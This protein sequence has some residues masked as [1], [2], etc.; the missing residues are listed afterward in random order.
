MDDAPVA[1]KRRIETEH[2]VDPFVY[3]RGTGKQLTETVD[4][5][6][7]G[8]IDKTADVAD[9]IEQCELRPVTI[10][11][12][13]AD[14]QNDEEHEGFFDEL[15]ALENEQVILEEKTVSERDMGQDLID[16]NDKL[17]LFAYLC[18]CG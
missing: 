4:E 12:S 14:D 8:P 5:Q 3:L 11:V 15:D 2:D 18:W 9:E 6:D 13:V 10:P 7:R 17:E 16:L 1:K